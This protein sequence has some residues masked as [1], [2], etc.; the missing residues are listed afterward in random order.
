MTHKINN[1]TC[2]KC[3][4]CT[5]VCPNKMIAKDTDGN[6]RFIAER[7]DMCVYCAQCM[8]VCETN[9]VIIDKLNAT[10]CLTDIEPNTIKPEQFFNFLAMRRSVRNFKDKPVTAEVIQE[11]LKMVN[12]APFGAEDDGI[13][14][15][16]IN[17]RAIIEKAL[18]LMSEFFVKLEKWLKNPAMR[19]FMKRK[20]APDVFNTIDLH[21][22]PRLIRKHYDTAHGN[23][24]ITRHAP[25]ILIFHAPRN[26]PE[27]YEDAYIYVTYAALAAHALGLGATING[28]VPSAINKTPALKQMFKIPQN[29]RAVVALL[30]GYPKIHYTKGIIHKAKKVDFIN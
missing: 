11:I 19:F 23:D 2:K 21:L 29:N 25:A 15:V 13:E 30:L 12:M 5:M 26:A 6:I 24:H 22:M 4:L 10:E 9:S 7:L 17:N 28:L 27:H 20:L 1:E 16:A 3:L 14:I 18:P 8:A